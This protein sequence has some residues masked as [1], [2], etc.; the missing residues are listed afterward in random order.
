M[1]GRSAPQGSGPRL[2]FARQTGSTLIMLRGLTAR[3][4]L[5]L[6]VLIL[7][8]SLVSSAQVRLLPDEVEI[9][10]VIAIERDGREVYAFDALTG[11][12]SRIR[13]ELGETVLFER[14]R[15]RVGLVLTNRRALG[16]ASGIG[17]Q[18]LRYRIQE[19]APEVGLV[20]DRL[21]LVVTGRRAL[22]FIGRGAWVEARFTPYEVVSA[23]RIG[24]GVGVVITNRRVLGLAPDLARFVETNLQLREELESVAAR[25]TQ[26]TIRTNRRILVFSAP[27]GFWSVQNRQIN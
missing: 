13:L 25:D 21:A 3:R 14:S 17:W 19:V 11:R 23:L 15:G 9:V 16:V 22:G 1:G 8:L 12:R 4:S 10:D 5:G 18:E 7:T 20:E 2:A 6:T 26:G 24:S 27:R